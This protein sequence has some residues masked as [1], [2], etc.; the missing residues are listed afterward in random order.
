MPSASQLEEF[1]IKVEHK[2]HA[3]ILPLSTP[4]PDHDV[5][6]VLS[7]PRCVAA[8]HHHCPSSLPTPFREQRSLLQSALRLPTLILTLLVVAVLGNLAAVGLGMSNNDKAGLTSIQEKGLKYTYLPAGE[9]K[10]THTKSLRL[11]AAVVG[12]IGHIFPIQM[13]V[14]INP[15]REKIARTKGQRIFWLTVVTKVAH[16]MTSMM[17]THGLMM[18]CLLLMQAK[19]VKS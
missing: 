6:G 11:Q 10:K 17:N 7:S 1:G 13:N 15:W 19:L 3:L 9:W 12:I 4:S 18:T 16:A 2:H 5:V 8:H 14:G